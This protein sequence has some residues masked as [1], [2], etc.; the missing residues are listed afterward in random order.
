MLAAGFLCGAKQLKGGL[1]LVTSHLVTSASRALS[2]A[3][4]PILP[5]LSTLL[6][7]S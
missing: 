7:F 2:Q 5:F 3:F 6:R 1:D 4:L